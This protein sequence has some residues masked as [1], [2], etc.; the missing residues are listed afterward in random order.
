MSKAFHP[1]LISVRAVLARCFSSVASQEWQLSPVEGLTGINW[2]AQLSDGVTYLVRPQTS[3]KTQLGIER[4]R[5][6]QALQLAAAHD[7]APQS[8]G[9]HDGW[10]VTEWL[11]GEVLNETTYQPHLQDL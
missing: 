5:E 1:S 7:L 3:E 11:S 2:K 8:F 4:K 6:A 10:L 9:L